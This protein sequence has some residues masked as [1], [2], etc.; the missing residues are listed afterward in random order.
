[1]LDLRAGVEGDKWSVFGFV[2]NV[3]NRYYATYAQYAQFTFGSPP[4]SNQIYELPGA[5]R[6]VGVRFQYRF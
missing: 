5:P 4:Y 3:L 1:V 2:N 6:L